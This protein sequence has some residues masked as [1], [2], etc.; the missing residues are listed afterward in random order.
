MFAVIE[1]G[2]KQYKVV[3]GDLIQ[4]EKLPVDDGGKV[5]FDKVLLVSREGDIK[6]GAPF[7]ESA[8]I[9]ATKVK[10]VKARKITVFK[11][12]R[13]KNYKRKTGH[14]QQLSLVKIEK[15]EI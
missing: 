2:G 14:R 10:D 11:Y 7:V 6:V 13:R 5:L 12:K 9:V 1:T 15:F 4:V 3:E 8:K